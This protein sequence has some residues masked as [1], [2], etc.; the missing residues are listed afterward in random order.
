VPSGCIRQFPVLGVIIE[1]QLIAYGSGCWSILRGL[2]LRAA[3]QALRSR[4]A[5]AL[6]LL[7]VSAKPFVQKAHFYGRQNPRAPKSSNAG[8]GALFLKSRWLMAVQEAPT[9]KA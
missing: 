9:S 3:S 7:V 6:V 8:L 4:A 1:D 2:G 5:Q